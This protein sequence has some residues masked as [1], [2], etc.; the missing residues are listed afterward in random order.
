MKTTA[1]TN[2]KDWGKTVGVFSLVGPPVGWISMCVCAT[3]MG[4]LTQT[5]TAREVGTMFGGMI[6]GSLFSYLIGGIPAL[7]TGTV[8][9][10]FR[11]RLTTFVSWLLSGGVGLLFTAIFFI[12]FSSDGWNKIDWNSFFNPLTYMG[13]F[14]A[15]VCAWL[16]RPKILVCPPPLPPII[17][18]ENKNEA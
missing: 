3:I 10:L 1:R 18:P 11:H 17:L 7:A 4:I 16:L 14:S 5:T 8:V 2:W 9:G 12:N 15:F 6:F 13:G